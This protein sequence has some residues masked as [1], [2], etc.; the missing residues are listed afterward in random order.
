MSVGAIERI[1]A[2]SGVVNGTTSIPFTVSDDDRLVAVTRPLNAWQTATDLSVAG[3]K[4]SQD[5]PNLN[6]TLTSNL[7][8]NPNS[9]YAITV[10][11]VRRSTGAPTVTTSPTVTAWVALTLYRNVNKY[12]GGTNSWMGWYDSPPKLMA[13]SPSLPFQSPDGTA[14]CLR[15]LGYSLIPVLAVVDWPEYDNSDLTELAHWTSPAG[16]P[17]NGSNTVAGDSLRV[18]V[19]EEAVTT[20]TGYQSATSRGAWDEAYNSTPYGTGM[21]DTILLATT[22]VPELPADPL[23]SAPAGATRLPMGGPIAAG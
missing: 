18:T 13:A 2:W 1:G 19:T 11:R 3:F 5:Y 12:P 21:M 20:P 22:N 4:L 14:I 15:V 16:S 10:Y 23:N 8:V 6:S 7:D 9:P 17:D